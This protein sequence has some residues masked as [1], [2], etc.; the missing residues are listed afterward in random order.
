[1]RITFALLLLLAPAG[2]QE[3]SSAV[4]IVGATVLTATK[5]VIEK[6]TVI[7]E[8]GK[9]T[10]VG[11]DV[12]VPSGATVIDGTGKFLTPGIIDTHSHMGVYAWPEVKANSDGN[13]A[14]HPIMAQVRAEDGV[15]LEDPAFKRALAGG[16]TTIQ[17]LPGSANMVGGESFVCKLRLGSLETMRF[18]GA[19]RGLKMA[20]GEN[21][22]RVYGGRGQLP[23]TRM[24]NFAVLREHFEKAR[25]YKRKWEGYAAKKAKGEEASPPD[26]DLKLETLKDVMEGKVRVHIHCYRMDEMAT[27]IAIAKEFGFKIASFQHALEAYKVADLLAKEDIAIA[28]WADWWGF[29]MEAWDGIPWNAALCAKAGVRTSIHSDS[30]DGVQRLYTEAAKCIRYGLSEE[31]ALRSI[32]YVPAT[33]LGVEKSTGSIEAGKDADLALFSKHPFDVTTLVEKT[34][35]DGK[36]VFDRKVNKD[37]YGGVR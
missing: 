28:T 22:K 7:V 35:I 6:G 3:R 25:E 15:N 24:G 31:D 1:M 8:N 34:W 2:A 23:S 16:L 9:I 26:K 17:I 19:P 33:M 32:T 20:S 13:E 29:K 14:T 37:Y 27:L 10:A 36:L 11:K 12:A 30:S 5:G 21:P 4:A 18:E